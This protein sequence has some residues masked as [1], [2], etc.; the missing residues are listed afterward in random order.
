MMQVGGSQN[1]V[2]VLALALL[3]AVA[4][5]AASPDEART[6]IK[7]M[8]EALLSRS[9][10]GVLTH[11]WVGG[12]EALRII[13]R[14]QGGRMME[15]VLS[16]DGSGHEEIRSGTQWIRYLPDKRIALVQT[17]N[18][19]FGYI[20]TLN[21]LNADSDKHYL[22]S[23]GGAQRLLGWPGPTQFIAVEPRDALRHGYRFWLDQ[24]TAMPVKTQLVTKA[25]EVI[26][27]ITFSS[28]QLVDNIPDSLL[29]PAADVR[30]YHAMRIDAHPEALTQAFAPQANLLPPGFRLLSLDAAAGDQPPEGPRSRFIVS[31]GITWVSVFVEPARKV[32]SEGPAMPMGA[33]E[34]YVRKLGQHYITV[35]GDVPAAA[36]RT[37]AEA[38]RP[39]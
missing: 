6:W 7:R 34:S 3:W 24:K 26:D 27:E 11:K 8:N 37:I 13:H 25:G 17:R 23:N 18:R 28:L 4:V 33:S 38:F 21:G 39:E 1:R 19:S 15:R 32:R 29:R 36:V 9:Y 35:V 5:P 16:T 12:G 31:D 20:T 30:G 2:C 14:V 10:D 22:I